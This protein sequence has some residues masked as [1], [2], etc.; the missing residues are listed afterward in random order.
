MRPQP[1]E[2]SR[3]PLS[4][5]VIHILLA[6]ADGA[7]HGYAIK[8]GVEERTNGTIRLGP[9]TLYEAVQRLQDDGL[10]EEAISRAGDSA[11]GQQAQRRYYTLTARGWDVLR[12]ELRQLDLVLERARAN[13]KLRKGLT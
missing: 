1:P 3:K 13:P 5:P 4:L 10:I 8:Q 2:P 6:L 11:N 7:L 9:G 12:H